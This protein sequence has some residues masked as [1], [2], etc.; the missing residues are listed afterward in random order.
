MARHGPSGRQINHDPLCQV[1]GK[2]DLCLRR[3]DEV[4]LLDL[5]NEQ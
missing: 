1:L 4:L 3:L 2:A 5:L